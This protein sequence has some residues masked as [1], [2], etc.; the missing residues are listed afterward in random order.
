M[1]KNIESILS[2]SK[3]ITLHP[4]F[5]R[6]WKWICLSK[7]EKNRIN[8]PDVGGVKVGRNKL[9]II[10]SRCSSPRYKMDSCTIVGM[11][12]DN[13]SPLGFIFLFLSQ[14]VAHIDS[15]KTGDGFSSRLNLGRIPKRLGSFLPLD[16]PR[17][18]PLFHPS[19]F[20]SASIADEPTSQVQ[21]R[22]IV[23]ISKD[24]TRSAFVF[25]D[26]LPGSR[27]RTHKIAKIIFSFCYSVN[28]GTKRASDV[29]TSLLFAIFFSSPLKYLP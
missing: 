5:N 19:A 13:P 17:F 3:R 25:G 15:S 7:Y 11:Q 23:Y 22:Y 1:Y 8:Y 2:S 29:S 24:F 20:A 4:Y 10:S 18:V 27:R 12:T 9:K 21:L 26:T 6:V 28:I 14:S 16:P